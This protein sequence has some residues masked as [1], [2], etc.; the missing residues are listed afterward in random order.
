MIQLNSTNGSFRISDPSNISNIEIQLD[1]EQSSSADH[2]NS[3]VSAA[4]ALI[5]G[6][7]GATSTYFYGRRI[8]R[9][10]A[11]MEKERE[12]EFDS[13]LRSLIYYELR[14]YYDLIDTLLKVQDDK[15]GFVHVEKKMLPRI[16]DKMA[17]PNNYKGIT[18]ERKARLFQ[19]ELLVKIESAYEIFRHISSEFNE[20]KAISRSKLESAISDLRDI[21]GIS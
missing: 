17:T 8:E 9:D 19:G 2:T 4:S 21:L 18:V 15:T 13:S 12:E 5:G 7:V 16:L 10:K 11:K 6:I 14:G 1:H 20:K 3:I